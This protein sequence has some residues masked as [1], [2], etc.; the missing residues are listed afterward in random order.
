MATTAPLRTW[1]GSFLSV[2]VAPYHQ[3]SSFQTGMP[4]PNPEGIE[5]NEQAGGCG[6]WQRGL[7]LLAQG[8]AAAGRGIGGHWQRGWQLLAQGMGG[9]WHRGWLLLAEGVAAAGKGG[10]GRW[11]NTRSREAM[12]TGQGRAC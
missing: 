7:R 12:G 6:Y 11:Q 8:V 1:R 9:C 5:H 3:P 10:H 2:S 4:R